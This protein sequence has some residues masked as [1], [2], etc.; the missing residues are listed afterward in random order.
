MGI[1]MSKVIIYQGGSLQS[2][3]E[4]R[5]E[6]LLSKYHNY[7]PDP[8]ANS[9]SR[10]QLAEMSYYNQLREMTPTPANST[11]PIGKLVY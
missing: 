10:G 3:Y 7:L 1:S 2:F 11:T 5:L 4:E 9:I 8:H 6:Y